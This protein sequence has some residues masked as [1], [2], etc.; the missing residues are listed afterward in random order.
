MTNFETMRKFKFEE[1]FFQYTFAIPKAFRLQ[2]IL[3]K[4]IFVVEIEKKI[5][6]NNLEFISNFIYALQF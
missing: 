4:I 6:G 5:D 3:K 1:L 2:W